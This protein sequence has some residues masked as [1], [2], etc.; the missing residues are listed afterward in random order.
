MADPWANNAD[1]PLLA[2]ADP[3]AEGSGA[4]EIIAKAG[5]LL[6]L[7]CSGIHLLHNMEDILA[8]SFVHSI[9]SPDNLAKGPAGWTP[10]QC[11][12]RGGP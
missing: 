4:V 5:D 7:P 9:A 1:Q 2:H 3:S 8:V 11:V 10:A 12:H 6:F